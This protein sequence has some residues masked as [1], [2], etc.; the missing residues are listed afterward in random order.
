MTYIVD[1]MPIDIIYK[2]IYTY[3]NKYDYD[4]FVIITENEERSDYLSRKIK[5]KCKKIGAEYTDDGKINTYKIANS[6][7]KEDRVIITC[8]DYLPFLYKSLRDILEDYYL[9][10]INASE[11]FSN[12]Y[13]ASKFHTTREMGIEYVKPEENDGFLRHTLWG[14]R[15]FIKEGNQV[16]TLNY[17][18]IVLDSFLDVCIYTQDFKKDLKQCF[19]KYCKNYNYITYDEL[20]Q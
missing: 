4:S 13:D 11:P 16:K 7:K 17:P 6:I 14:T 2:D 15:S 19:D 18:E 10:I 5:G 8:F 1:K 3:I 9:L 20:K 12:S